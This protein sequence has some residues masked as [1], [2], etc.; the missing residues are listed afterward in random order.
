MARNYAVTI[1]ASKTAIDAATLAQRLAELLGQ[2]TEEVEKAVV[3]GTVIIQRELSYSEAIEFQ[4]EL[5]R[6][7]I[8]A[9]VSTATDVEGVELLLRRDSEPPESKD[10]SQETGFEGSEKDGEE[11][12]WEENDMEGNAWADLFPGLG[13][14]EREEEI[15][16]SVACEIPQEQGFDEDRNSGEEDFEADFDAGF[17]AGFDADFDAGFDAELEEEQLEGEQD[18]APEAF[19]GAKVRQAFVEHDEERPP[20][21]PKNYDPRPPHV[22]L[23]AAVLSGIAPGAGQVFN[24]QPQKAQRFGV[25]FF[26]IYPWYRAIRQAWEYGEKIQ[27][28]YAPRPEKGVGKAA[29]KYVVK[30]WAAVLVLV[31]FSSW[32]VASIEEYRDRQLQ[33]QQ[34]VALQ[35]LIYYS[36]DVVID[37]V[38]DAEDAAAKAEIEDDSEQVTKM[39]NQE[40]ARRLFIVGYHQ[41][42]ANEY[43]LCEAAMRRVTSLVNDNRDAFRLQTWASIQARGADSEM[44][45]PDVGEVPTLEEFELE[46][47]ASGE[48]VESLE[49]EWWDEGTTPTLVDP[50]GET[51]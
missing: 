37:G 3:K 51:K 25:I 33:Q 20:F 29:I 46:L 27:T 17:D 50:E 36:Q 30:W 44:A 26:L 14:E 5:S 32:M 41:C 9:Q 40:R 28:H 1:T 2:P 4:R 13:Q 15:E 23:V 6:R 35:H 49:D 7:K 19:D 31:I 48:D 38:M 8:P 18:R 11:F 10:S 45:M 21:A 43:Q 34:R 24:G 39:E 47:T 42:V 12:F 16:A 22:P